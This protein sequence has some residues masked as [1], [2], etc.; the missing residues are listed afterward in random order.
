MNCLPTLSL[1]IFSCC[2]LGVGCVLQPSDASDFHYDYAD[3]T[4]VVVDVGRNGADS[5]QRAAAAPEARD[6]GADAQSADLDAAV[7]GA[8]TVPDATDAAHETDA[9]SVSNVHDAGTREPPN[10]VFVD[11]ILNAR[12]LGGTA[13]G[14]GLH[15][16][17]G[18]LYR[19][20]ALA[21]FGPAGCA[22]FRERAIHTV[23]DLRVAT[24][25]AGLP[26][27]PCVAETARITL[28]PMPIPYNVNAADY[29]TVL[30][31]TSSIA[32][33]FRDLG[34]PS[35]YPIY[36]HCTYGRDRSGVVAALVL[37]ALGASRQVILDEYNLSRLQVGAYPA[38][39]EGALDEIERRGGIETYLAAAGVSAE[40]L[41]VLR[42]RATVRGR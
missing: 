3:K 2:W 12:D 21:G 31:T 41:A 7:S 1:T 28:A 39:L 9:S 5:H 42:D 34:T 11:D 24:E 27:S 30:N 23:I 25:V 20:P 13:L 18:V 8:A 36:F 35:A 10:E 40:Q 19:G 14:A 37:A 38:A 4:R 26:E 16:A 6:A 33:T 15:V 32:L 29:I 22:E 17:P